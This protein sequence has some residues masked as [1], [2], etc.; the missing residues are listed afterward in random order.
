[1]TQETWPNSLARAQGRAIKHYRELIGLKHAELAK[2]LTDAGVPMQRTT[3]VNIEQGLRKSMSVPEMFA[4]GYVLGVPP[5]M[6]MIPLGLE[7]E[8]EPIQG[9]RLDTWRAFEWV[10][11]GLGF[12]HEF[13]PDNSEDRTIGQEVRSN[14][15]AFQN[16][17][18][19]LLHTHFA[20][21]AADQP[22]ILKEAKK[23]EKN[24]LELLEMY[25]DVM[26]KKGLKLP[27]LPAV[28]LED[29]PRLARHYK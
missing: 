25:F 9:H 22:E 29:Y 5:A 18:E 21:E 20:L 1:M 28:L 7:S 17:V 12:G 13:R 2:L 8:V 26:E 3:L 15:M 14:Y 16:I 6:L 24:Q 10:S 4:L 19:E 27:L 11:G 23:R